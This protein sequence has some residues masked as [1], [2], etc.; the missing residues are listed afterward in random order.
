MS[1]FKKE[2]RRK[3]WGEAGAVWAED[4]VL[5]VLRLSSA[6]SETDDADLKQLAKSLEVLIGL[7]TTYDEVV[8]LRAVAA[9]F[10]SCAQSCH[11]QLLSGAITLLVQVLFLENS[12]PLHKEVLSVLRRLPSAWVQDIEAA[13]T[14]QLAAAASNEA[15]YFTLAGPLV[16][17]TACSQPYAEIPLRTTST[18]CASALCLAVSSVTSQAAGG[19]YTP[20]V[21]AEECQDAL[22]ALYYLLHRYSEQFIPDPEGD[23]GRATALTLLADT[24]S[25]ILSTTYFTRESTVASAVSFIEAASLG[26]A[27]KE[28][29]F[30][31]AQLFFP[32][33]H[34]INM[35]ATLFEAHAYA[36]R[37]LSLAKV[38]AEFTPFGYLCC[39]RAMLKALPLAVLL[40]PVSAIHTETWTLLY[41]G[42]LP[43]LCSAVETA[44]DGH[45]K[46]HA[47]TGLQMCLQHV[48]AAQLRVDGPEAVADIEKSVVEDLGRFTVNGADETTPCMA[49]LKL[50][51][52]KE[53]VSRVLSVVWNNWEDP[54][55]QTVRQVQQVFELL[56]DITQGFED[57]LMLKQLANELVAIG[58]HR[59][60]KHIT[61]A[62]VVPRFGATQLVTLD[63]NLMHDV[64]HAMKEDSLCGAVS[65]FLK[66][67]LDHL[68][69][70]CSTMT[71]GC[72]DDGRSFWLPAVL[73]ALLTEDHKLRLNVSTYA[74]PIALAKGPEVLVALLKAVLEGPDTQKAAA[75]VAVLKVGRSLRML[76][77][78]SIERVT[79]HGQT[80][81]EIPLHVIQDAAISSSEALRADALELL[82]ISAKATALPS[83]LDMQ[84]LSQTIP[85]NL[86]PSGGSFRQRWS[87]VLKK[88]LLRLKE[89]L[90]RVSHA[91]KVRLQRGV[92]DEDV[93]SAVS[94]EEQHAHAV[95]EFLRW[96]SRLFFAS[97]YPTAPYERKL[98]AIEMLNTLAEFWT[99]TE[100]AATLTHPV[101]HAGEHTFPYS[102]AAMEPATLHMLL[103]NMLQ[104][105]DRLRDGAYQL[106]MKYPT[107]LPG[108][109]SP[110][111]L[112]PIVAWAKN[113]LLSPRVREGDAAA[114]VL[115][116]VFQKYVVSLGWVISLHPKPQIQEHCVDCSDAISAWLSTL[117]ASLDHQIQLARQDLLASC[118]GGLVHGLLLL[119]RYSLD[120]INWTAAVTSRAISSL[121]DY[122]A[123][124]LVLLPQATELASWAVSSSRFNV[125]ESF[126]D[127]DNEDAT[128]SF[129][130]GGH[131]ETHGQEQSLS[132]IDAQ[133]VL[134]ASW[135]S[136]KEVSLVLGT[137]A[138][139]LPI[140]SLPATGSAEGG[141]SWV[142]D[143]AQLKAMG[144]LLVGV[145]LVLKHNGAVDKAHLGLAALCERLL[146]SGSAELSRLPAQWVG[147]LFER[148]M[149]PGQSLT[150]LVR[151]SAGLPFAFVSIFTAEPE[152]SPKVLL[153]GAMD[154]LLALATSQASD[155]FVPQVHAF[156]VLRTIF[157]HSQLSADTSAF[158]APAMEAAIRAFTSPAWPVRNA[159]TLAFTGLV[160]RTVGFK[161]LQQQA[162]SR[163]A[164]TGSEYFHRSQPHPSLYPVL[165]LLSRLRPSAMTITE[166]PFSPKAFLEDVS[167]CAMQ[168]N[169]QIRA[170]AARAL[171]PLV[172]DKDLLAYLIR[173]AHGLPAASTRGIDYNKTHGL[174]LQMHALLQQSGGVIA[175]HSATSEVT[176]FI[177]V[178]SGKSW[179][180]SLSSCPCPTI[181]AAYIA[182]LN[183][184]A[185]ALGTD[186]AVR[187]LILRLCQETL[188][189]QDQH[190][191]DSTCIDLRKQSTAIF[192]TN[193]VHRKVSITGSLTIVVRKCLADPAYEVRAS[194]LRWLRKTPYVV[195]KDAIDVAVI[196]RDLI[197]C[198]PQEEVLFVWSVDNTSSSLFQGMISWQQLWQLLQ[199]T[200]ATARQPGLQEAALRYLGICLHYMTAGSTPAVSHEQLKTWCE[201]IMT[202]SAARQTASMR[203]AAVDAILASNM[204]HLLL[205]AKYAPAAL[206]T[207]Q[208]TLHVCGDENYDT[209][210]AAARA[211]HTAI[212]A[213]GTPPPQLEKVLEAAFAHLTSHCSLRGELVEFYAGWI[214]ADG[215]SALQRAGL[216]TDRTFEKDSDNE[217]EEHLHFVQLAAQ[218]LRVMAAGSEDE[219]ILAWRHKYLAE[220]QACL[221]QLRSQ[222]EQHHWL[223]ALTN[224]PEVFLVL[225]RL[226]MGLFA[227]GQPT[228]SAAFVARLH[229]TVSSLKA[230]HLTAVLQLVL[231]SAMSA[232]KAGYQLSA[233]ELH[234]LYFLLSPAMPA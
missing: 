117:L 219:R 114:L 161:N 98:M 19:A 73:S 160:H 212:S 140:Q 132:S 6:A 45:F 8:H 61:L 110:S 158:C 197:E 17:L 167:S 127:F 218:Q 138:R 94:A 12:R 223:E 150:D 190:A 129:H 21:Q 189:V 208:V 60:G 70:E 125:A 151:R 67:I 233:S 64:V 164:I 148:I 24:L 36:A 133:T 181:S 173:T 195:L 10:S 11:R 229:E 163:H 39:F 32:S 56:L 38:I 145:L 122:M 58:S 66:V 23:N 113:M 179:L 231:S 224:S 121:R 93:D 136:V 79:Q 141:A 174:L 175:Q 55:A 118:N 166:D 59:K 159:A 75:L 222:Q 13:L 82:C 131:A 84:L 30:L 41:D 191:W 171:A 202:Y 143:L 207:W 155:Y 62:A 128:E 186:H 35:P 77:E 47:M 72:P 68:A 104:S 40:H 213:P 201:C 228:A 116:L 156:N 232:Y 52:S 16:S 25:G 89:S 216:E 105:F 211:L 184:V 183:A 3:R 147:N 200:L 44:I 85:L 196:A 198:L 124:L 28:A 54:A 194:A 149:Q 87:A 152:S 33:S 88:F 170:L 185:G 37:G 80:L 215:A 220:L 120:A 153:P 31:L 165:I 168:R 176:E 49:A 97:L 99:P 111:Q 144:E 119:M 20:R 192:L 135:L 226:T 230:L 50:A 78:A 18:H 227:V 57:G 130:E 100:F 43:A 2:Q 71:G 103:F 7:S 95:W 205:V 1:K 4:Y 142:L 46:Y 177:D 188:A 193:A 139:K 81:L 34:R 65:N 178:V 112:Q 14:A 225:Y 123:Q 206:L 109:E 48:K 29:A 86:R 15:L 69:I 90:E 210:A 9:A 146:Q 102:A 214:L 154:Q 217:Y 180:G 92:A 106:L 5:E 134:V 234:D 172:A 162:S 96:L 91:R 107:P 203:R 209:R 182:V 101:E 187:D 126:D 169:W 157:Q 137:M 51:V 42:L 74:L 83:L 53:T 26:C 108:L 115:K 22:S 63:P 27:E 204:L 199:Q 76:D 221:P